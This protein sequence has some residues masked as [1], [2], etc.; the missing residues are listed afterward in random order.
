MESSRN[1][2]FLSSTLCS[3]LRSHAALNM[4]HT[5][6]WHIRTVDAAYQVAIQEPS[7]LSDQL[8]VSLRVLELSLQ[9]TLNNG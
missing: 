2:P 3:F 9:V 1:K 8:L 7:W 6:V 5:F 4:S